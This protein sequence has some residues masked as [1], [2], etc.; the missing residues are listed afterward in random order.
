[1]ITSLFLAEIKNGGITPKLIIVLEY[2]AKPTDTPCEYAVKP[3]RPLLNTPGVEVS[4]P[5]SIVK[6]PP[7]TP[8][9]GKIP[10][11]APTWGPNAQTPTFFCVPFIHSEVR[12]KACIEAPTIKDAPTDAVFPCHFTKPD[13]SAKVSGFPPTYP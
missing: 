1:L 6:S 3:N 7:V 11:P 5:S 8:V 13:G 10:S 12:V 2:P 4:W 9:G